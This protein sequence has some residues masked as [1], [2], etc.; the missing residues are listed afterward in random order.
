[1]K[2]GVDRKYLHPLGMMTPTIVES[3]GKPV[4]VTLLDANHCPGA[5]MFLF[6]VGKRRILHVGDF[7]WNRELMMKC[8]PL[9]AFSTLKY[10]LDDL[11]LD[12]TY[13]EEKYA[14]PTQ[15]EAIQAAV[16]VAEKEW[17]RSKSK[18]QKTLFLFGAYTIG[19]EKIYLSV[20]ERLRTRIYVDETRYRTLS[21]LNWPR[22]RMS[23]LTTNPDDSCLRVVPLG[24]VNFKTMQTYL[25]GPSDKVFSKKKY[26]RIVGFRPTGWSMSALGNGIVSTQ[27]KGS[28]TVHGIPYSEHSSFNELVDCLDCLKPKRIIP[29]V[30]VAKSAEQ[31]ELLLSKLRAKQGL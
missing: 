15:A 5:V 11:F 31:V 27:T 30:S 10:R 23:L 20:A 19:K 16:E 3:K 2:L 8:A 18:G 25:S 4:S 7:R 14:L 29:T 24:H 26:D 9:R 17:Q 21:S 28:F 6:E 13:C 12:T 1:M 22:D